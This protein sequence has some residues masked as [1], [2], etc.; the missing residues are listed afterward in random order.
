MFVGI[1][2]VDFVKLLVLGRCKFVDN[3]FYE[4]ICYRFYIDE[5]LNFVE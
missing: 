1:F 5:Y 3:D 2:F 4:K